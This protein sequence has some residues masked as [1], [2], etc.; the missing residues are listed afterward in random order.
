VKS[1]YLKGIKIERIKVER[2]GRNNNNRERNDV[3]TT[4]QP[5][6]I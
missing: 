3:K 4:A 5:R 2:Y 6:Q 1:T